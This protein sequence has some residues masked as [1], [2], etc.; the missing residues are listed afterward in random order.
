MSKVQKI[1]ISICL[2]VIA[3]LGV[4]AI[5]LFATTTEPLKLNGTFVIL[6]GE[7]G[8]DISYDSL[9][10][11]DLDVDATVTKKAFAITGAEGK[12]DGFARDYKFST[13]NADDS[14]LYVSCK[15]DSG[16]TNLTVKQAH[17]TNTAVINTFDSEAN[18][19]NK[20]LIGPVTDNESFQKALQEQNLPTEYKDEIVEEIKTSGTFVDVY[21]E[22][23]EIETSYDKL[24]HHEAKLD[25]KI[26]RDK[27][28]E[29]YATGTL[30]I[31]GTEYHIGYINR[32]HYEEDGTDYLFLSTNVSIHHDISI[33]FEN[34]NYDSMIIN[35]IKGD[36]GSE[37]E[38]GKTGYLIGP[39]KDKDDWTR[40]LKETH[41]LPEE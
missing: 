13:A 1:I 32:Q 5:L 37:N 22:H 3:L 14:A 23:S 25:V 26:K 15:D 19:G 29:E 6:S 35:V 8:G 40:V 39:V 21:G 24:P 30:D 2:L 36:L 11:I 34:N 10:K 33:Q 38:Y 16:L 41:F 7:Y 4:S 9:T 20:T 28:G 17:G 12:L 31:D 18:G 27:K